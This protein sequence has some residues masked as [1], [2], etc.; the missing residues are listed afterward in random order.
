[1]ALE[2]SHSHLSLFFLLTESVAQ[3]CSLLECRKR[4]G[5]QALDLDAKAS[6]SRGSQSAPLACRGSAAQGIVLPVFWVEFMNARAA[7]WHFRNEVHVST[8]PE[9]SSTLAWLV[10][11][12]CQR[13]LICAVESWRSVK[14][15]GGVKGS[16][17]LFRKKTPGRR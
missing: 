4:A 3:C 14:G 1:M 7:C 6:L 5:S 17:L 16:A 9:T 2:N 12:I 10:A 8:L 15:S 13:T 11:H